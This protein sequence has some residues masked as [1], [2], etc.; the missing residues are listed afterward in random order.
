VHPNEGHWVLRNGHAE[1]RLVGGNLCTLNLLHGTAWMP[2]LAGSVVFIEDDRESS[3][4]TFNRD[5]TS[6]AQQPGFSS[7][8]AVLIGRF[9]PHLGMDRDTLAA[10]VDSKPELDGKPV[11]A[12]IDFGHTDPI[13]TIPVG[14]HATIDAGPAGAAISF[15]A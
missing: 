11:V 13:L 5:L 3:I 15:H 7:V 2:D 8:E 12:N 1:G 6:L 10:I 4:V 9:E 14:G